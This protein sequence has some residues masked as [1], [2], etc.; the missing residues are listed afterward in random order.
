MTSAL[1]GRDGDANEVVS[2]MTGRAKYKANEQSKA[3]SH[4]HV[5]ESYI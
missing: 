1:C 4:Y 2:G 3:T 5:R